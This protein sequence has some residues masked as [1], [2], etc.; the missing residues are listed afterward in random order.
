[1]DNL[2]NLDDIKVDTELLERTNP[3]FNTAKMTLYQL[4]ASGDEDAIRLVEK[5]GLTE[6]TQNSTT[7]TSDAVKLLIESL[8]MD[9]RYHTIEKLAM[10]EGDFTEIDLPCGYLPKAL[11]YTKAGHRFIGLDLPA[12]ISE[13]EPAINTLLNE[14]QKKMVKF[15]GV[16]A[17]NYDSL[18]SALSDVEGKVVIT[19]EGL[20]VYFNDSEVGALCDNVKRILDEHGGCWLTIDPEWL[21]AYLLVVK[22]ILG[23]KAFEALD[24]MKKRVEDKSDVSVKGNALVIRP[25]DVIK[26][27]LKDDITEDIKK[28]MEFLAKHGLKAE[29]MIV[30]YHMPELKVCEKLKPEQIVAVK[31]AMKRNAYWKITSTG[32]PTVR[33]EIDTSGIAEKNFDIKA[34]VK[35]ER[36]FI[37]LTGR[38]DSLTAPKVLSFYETI[39]KNI[40]EVYVDCTDL[41]YISSAGLRVLLIMK[42]KGDMFLENVRPQVMEILETTGF[43]SIFFGEK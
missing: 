23:D 36:L 9:M 6:D 30:A 11:R 37:S 39:S 41:Q 17:T 21:M 27:R 14:E 8:L 1:M 19:T 28:A 34:Q 24:S 40:K 29:R 4:A 42:K 16:D 38:I 2:F 25:K 13:I 22:A 26:A 31:E 7:T 15:A 5:L 3:I 32:M 33:E 43:D 20:M 10:E 35:G 12:T 18:K